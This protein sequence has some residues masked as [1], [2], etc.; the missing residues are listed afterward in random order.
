LPKAHDLSNMALAEL[1]LERYAD[2]MQ[3]AK[4][5][6]VWLRIIIRPIIL[7]RRSPVGNQ[8]GSFPSPALYPQLMQDSHLSLNA[9]PSDM[10]R[11]A[12]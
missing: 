5:A 11:S 2:A 9:N 3:S 1:K 8:L 6:L 4:S 7:V 12:V 10:S